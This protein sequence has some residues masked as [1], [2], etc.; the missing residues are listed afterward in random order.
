MQ[1]ACGG[2]TTYLAEMK[3]SVV[4]GLRPVFPHPYMCSGTVSAI[5]YVQIS[6][7]V[8]SKGGNDPVNISSSG[9]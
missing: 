6:G 9:V 4:H 8:K 5:E 3:S 1:V 7:F 2:D